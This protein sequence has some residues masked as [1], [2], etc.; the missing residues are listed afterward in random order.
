M[1]PYQIPP[2]VAM[3]MRAHVAS[4]EEIALLM[5]M[6]DASD[7]WWDVHLVSRELGIPAKEARALLDRF[8]SGNLLDIRVTDDVRYR[9]VPGTRELE[10]GA[11][12][13]AEAYR[14]HPAAVLQ[15]VSQSTSRSARDFADAFRLR[16]HGRS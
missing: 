6:I 5:A 15:S 1:P 14:T 8:A 9:F 4:V 7:R 13:F 2:L 12:A 11:A 3:F 10:Q 16:R